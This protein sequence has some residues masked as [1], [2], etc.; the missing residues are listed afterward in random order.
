MTEN[1]ANNYILHE[2]FL[3]LT[4]W[5][6]KIDDGSGFICKTEN[7]IYLATAFHVLAPS[8]DDN[9]SKNEEQIKSNFLI[10]STKINVY[11]NLFLM[12]IQANNG[13]EFKEIKL[14]EII[15]I[16]S[17]GSF[18]VNSC[19]I[20]PLK[21]CALIPIMP[22]YSF[23]NITINF[24]QTPLLLSLRARALSGPALVIQ[25]PGV[26]LFKEW[27]EQ[28]NKSFILGFDMGK[29]E[30]SNM[31]INNTFFVHDAS[32]LPGSS[33]SP[34]IQ[35]NNDET[36]LV[37]VHRGAADEKNN[38]YILLNFTEE[39]RE[40]PKIL[41][42]GIDLSKIFGEYQIMQKS[43]SVQESSL[44]ELSELDIN[45]ITNEMEAGIGLQ[46]FD[47]PLSNM[48]TPI[49]NERS[50]FCQGG[51]SSI[52]AYNLY[53]QAVKAFVKLKMKIKI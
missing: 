24:S 9:N 53:M 51:Y 42:N 10:N 11:V 19:I 3:N 28:K 35:F 49:E 38:Q 43:N 41:S 16:N 22:T 31:N 2:Q 20:K 18:D 15:N 7:K 44:P 1:Q 48:K 8:L 17:D 33:G 21:D 34:I 12:Q 27:K 13:K 37:G 23:E 45:H 32:T 30:S 52:F 47:I 29:I 25:Y 6:C 26:N 4:K 5:V 14:H 40:I 36:L 46:N 50:R 39:E